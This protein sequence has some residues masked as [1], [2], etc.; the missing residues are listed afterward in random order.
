MQTLLGKVDGLLARYRDHARMMWAV[1]PGWSTVSLLGTLVGAG[2]LVLS[3]VA[4]GQ[5]IGALYEVLAHRADSQR[6]W[7]W[8]AAFV[9]AAVLGQLQQ[10]VLAMANPR[11]WSPYRVMINDLL[12]ETGM[13]S[14][15]LAVLDGATAGELEN[16]IKTSRQ[17]LFRFGMTGIWQLLQTRLVGLGAVLVLVGWRWWAPLV[18]AAAFLLSSRLFSTWL[19]SVLDGMWGSTPP[20]ER[21]RADYVAKVMAS[22]GAAKEVRI[23]GLVDWLAERYRVLWHVAAAQFWHQLNRKLAPTFLGGLALLVVLGGTL[24]LLG[25]DAYRGM[26]N[27]SAVITYVLA[28]L[29]L[30]AFG[31]Q[32]DQQA[33]LVQVGRL[34]NDLRTLRGRLDLPSLTPAEGEPIRGTPVPD[35]GIKFE[36]VTFTYPT[37]TVPTL[38]GLTLHVPAG[39]SIAIVGVNGAGKS[40]MIKLL[41]GLYQADSGSVTVGGRD[42]FADPAL[43]RAVAVIFQ[44]FIHYPLSLRDNVGFGALERRSDTE[45]LERAMTD[46]AGRDVLASLDHAW[47]S[48][49]SS[50]YEDGTELSGGQWQRIALARALAAVGAGAQILVLDEPT[51]ALDVRAEAELFERFLSVTKGVTTVLVSHRLATVRRADRIV[52]LDGDTGKVT[53]DGT[54]D[55]LLA[56]G[57][58]Y[59]TMFRL[60]ARRF[61]QAGD[62][63]EGSD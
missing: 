18:V 53:E 40:T 6:A 51:A 58:A 49:L 42:A 10:A 35:A 56:Q 12:A 30:N 50:E 2:A 48:V 4:T 62:P 43:D 3:M 25:W 17:W 34:L 45:L 29:A 37:R 26:V 5:L 60:Q 57:G 22:S 16:L 1:A 38:S 14:R 41:A 55:E 47:D 46:A 59:A 27:S 19:D 7:W 13:H 24:S 21:Q 15:S 9:L 54:H 39:Q 63:D 23:F 52:V 61:A 36:G 8:F 11:I 20:I 33:G 32:G 31:M 28:L 44:D